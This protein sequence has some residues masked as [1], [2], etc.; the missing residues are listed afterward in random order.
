MNKFSVVYLFVICDE[1]D[2]K[3]K[4][5]DEV[6]NYKKFR[7]VFD[8]T[9]E[10]TPSD[11]EDISLFEWDVEIQQLTDEEIRAKG[12]KKYIVENK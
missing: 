9:T 5:P 6:K 10:E 2:S 12:W 8:T 4:H 3:W 7:S 11:E 1:C